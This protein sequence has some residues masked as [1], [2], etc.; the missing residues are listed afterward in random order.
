[1]I[2]RKDTS[3]L[4]RLTQRE[5]AAIHQWS[6]APARPAR[7]LL[8]HLGLRRGELLGLRWRAISTDI[9][10]IRLD[11]RTTKGRKGRT[12]PI[13]KPLAQAILLARFDLEAVMPEVFVAHRIAVVA[14]NWMSPTG[15]E[16]ADYTRPASPQTIDRIVKRAAE[17]ASLEAP[18]ASRATCSAGAC[19][20]ASS[21]PARAPT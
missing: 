6:H 18:A 3:S 20:N 21:K 7:D 17:L 10:T 8:V 12:V 1:M 16:G 4:R 19:S 11:P 15:D 14:L 5:V 2:P 13:P 9:G